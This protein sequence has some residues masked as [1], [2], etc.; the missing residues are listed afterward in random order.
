MFWF[1]FAISNFFMRREQ[2][3]KRSTLTF[4]QLVTRKNNE[5][6]IEREKMNKKHYNI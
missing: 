1:E 2:K 3:S 4:I 6:K 5:N